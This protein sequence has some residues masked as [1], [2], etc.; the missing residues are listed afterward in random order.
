MVKVYFLVTLGTVKE[1][2][3]PDAYGRANAERTTIAHPDAHTMPEQWLTY[4]ELAEKLGTTPEAAR[5]KANRGRWQRQLGNDGKARVLVDLDAPTVRARTS[6]RTP[7]AHPD[8]QSTEPTAIQVAMA[9]L[10]AHVI[11]LKDQV[12]KA[13]ALAAER[14]ALA[15]DRGREVSL[16]RERVADLTTQ[17]LNL[18]RELLEFHKTKNPPRSLWRK[19]I[20]LG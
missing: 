16:E 7:I 10:E 15:A 18:T 3:S 6:A 13:E 8:A 11:T 19:L 2:L 9:A 12:A 20:G 1:P 5:A 4:S 17:L 14:G